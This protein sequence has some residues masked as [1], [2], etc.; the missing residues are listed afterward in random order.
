[1]VP[2]APGP[3]GFEVDSANAKL[4]PMLCPGLQALATIQRPSAPAD[5][6]LVIMLDRHGVG[7]RFE[8][9]DSRQ[10]APGHHVLVGVLRIHRSRCR[11]RRGWSGPRLL[12]GAK[13]GGAV[14]AKL[15]LPGGLIYNRDSAHYRDP[16]DEYYIRD[17]HFDLPYS[18]AEIVS[19]GEERW[20]MHTRRASDCIPS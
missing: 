4:V 12:V 2:R 1:M 5:A 9:R 3:R 11:S 15:A 8:P 13:P 17:R 20:I 16:L 6:E 10:P 14:R 19:L 18:A 7:G